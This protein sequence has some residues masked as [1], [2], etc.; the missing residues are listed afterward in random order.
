MSADDLWEAVPAE[1]REAWATR[2]AAEDPVVK[3]VLGLFIKHGYHDAAVEATIRDVLEQRVV[4]VY[5]I[6]PE[7]SE[8]VFEQVEYAIRQETDAYGA[9]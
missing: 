5:G 3:G 1:A 4:A 9:A 6:K 7:Q 8:A 2:Q